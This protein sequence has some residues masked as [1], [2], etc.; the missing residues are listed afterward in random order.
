MGEL[1]LVNAR[2][3]TLKGDGSPRRGDALG[4]LGVIEQGWILIEDEL[5]KNLGDGSPPEG[6]EP[7]MVIDL[8]GRVILPGFVDCHTHACWAGSR[9]DEFQKMLEGATYLQLLE[10][11]GGI[12]STVRAVREAS[13]EQLATSLSE[14]FARMATWG[15][16]TIEVKSGYGLTTADELKM[17]RAIHDASVQ[18]TQLVTGTFMGAH[19][20]DPDIPDFIDRTIN[21]TLPAAVEEF[22]GI[23]C[24]A[25]CEQGAW[26]MEDTTRLFERATDLG[27]P[28]RV[29]TDQFNE[30]GMTDKAIEM[31]ARSVDHLEATSPAVIKR[32]GESET[33]AV[34]LPA[35][36]YCLDDRYAAGR[37]LIEAGA[38][39]ALA[40]NLNPGSAPCPSMPMAM[41]L[42]CR[43]CGLTPQE[44]IAASTYNAACVLG[45]QGQVGSL[46]PG[47]RADLVVLDTQDERELAWWVSAQPPPLIIQRGEVIQFL[48]DS[49]TVEEQGEDPEETGP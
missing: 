22:P 30:L 12:M 41:S 2:L 36:G 28:L 44:A 3:C 24:D 49:S 39:I 37:E 27:C 29:H 18:T 32:L 33:M 4:D 6:L 47:H 48:A 11:G 46:A 8:D 20:I 34:L 5:I 38:A 25:Y 16:S 19:A 1:L 45:L 10:E 14:Q 13:E 31:G 9:L 40:T 23:T 35:S 17:L 7:D 21:E 26:S 15:S 43:K 42:A